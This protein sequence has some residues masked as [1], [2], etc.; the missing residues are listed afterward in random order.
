M[1]KTKFLLV[2]NFEIALSGEIENE[3]ISLTDIC[4][5]L[6]NEYLID[7]WIRNQKTIEFLSVWEKI[8]NPN[9]KPVD[10]DGFREDSDN[11][12]T[13]VTVKRWISETAAEGIISRSGRYGGTYAHKDIAFEFC[14]WISAEFKFLVIKEF[15]RLK[16]K[17]IAAAPWKHK[18]LLASSNYRL[19]TDAI[20]E[21]IIPYENKPAGLIYA[22]EADLINI[23]VFGNTA[24]EW[25]KENPK[26]Y[27]AGQ[28]MR[29][30]ADIYQLIVVANMEALNSM[31]IAKLIPKEQR[32][33]QIFSE[34]KRQLQT[35]YKNE[36]KKIP[37]F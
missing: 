18:R 34:A 36:I 24:G 14:M 25:E 12:K 7:N 2:D 11:K 17:E 30:N 19:Q 29:D 32:E 37:N 6:Q 13:R 8:N 1:K 31:L 15:Q 20:Q 27:A 5:K 22:S 3:Y 21:N 10:F 35:F 23:A 28:N 4:R 33:L 26:L 9:F 16:E